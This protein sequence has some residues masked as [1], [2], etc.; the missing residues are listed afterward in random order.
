MLKKYALLIGIIVLK[1]IIQFNL[2]NPAYELQRDEFL[3]ID[4]GKH[5]AAGFISVPPLTALLR[6]LHSQHYNRG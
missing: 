6:F 3:H 4:Q 5:L 1:F 2:V